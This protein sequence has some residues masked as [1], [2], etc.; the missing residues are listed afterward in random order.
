[1]EPWTDKRRY[2]VG[3]Q[4]GPGCHSERAGLTL[5]SE[6]FIGWPFASFADVAAALA[7]AHVDLILLPV[8]NSTTGPIL[9]A[10]EA[11]RPFVAL[12]ETRLHIEHFV[13]AVPGAR[14]SHI[15]AV[16]AHPQVAKQ[17]AGWIQR[18]GLQLKLVDDGARRAP[19][20]LKS[21]RRDVAVLGP[22]G[23]GKATG[24]YPLEGPVQDQADNRTTFRLLARGE[25]SPAESKT[26]NRVPATA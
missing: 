11:S 24:L 13:M 23:I 18:N 26:K 19:A 17:C 5:L 6:R 8:F 2:T 22:V 14:M 16:W 20:F 15:K 10:L 4:G 1:M 3:Y 25:R 7:N 9:D 12:D 21:R